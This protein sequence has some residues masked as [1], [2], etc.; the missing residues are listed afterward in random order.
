MASQNR[1]H[2]TTEVWNGE[3]CNLQASPTKTLQENEKQLESEILS[4]MRSPSE[5]KSEILGITTKISRRNVSSLN[6]GPLLNIENTSV[7]SDVEISLQGSD[8]V[9][10]ISKVIDVKNKRISAFPDFVMDWLTRQT[11]E[12]T[13]SLFTPPN[14]T[15]IPPTDF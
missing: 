7:G 9:A 5:K 12:L 13:N 8:S 14:L 6:G 10:D 11:E 1:A 2:S 4:Y 15:I 3:S